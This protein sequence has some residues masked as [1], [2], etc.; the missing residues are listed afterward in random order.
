MLLLVGAPREA[1][2]Q[3]AAPVCNGKYKGTNP[4]SEELADI[5]KKHAQHDSK[6]SSLI[7]ARIFTAKTFIP[8]QGAN[9]FVPIRNKGPDHLV[10][11]TL[12]VVKTW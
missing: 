9:G 10:Q 8:M 4:S 1:M 2:A 5:L 3:P 6:F 7:R 11:A 12:G